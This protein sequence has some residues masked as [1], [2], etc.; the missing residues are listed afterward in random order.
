MI[1]PRHRKFDAPVR[2][3]AT[4]ALLLGSLPLAPAAIT[5][6]EWAHVQSLEV[7][8]AGLTKISLP[9]STLDLA[10]AGLADLRV[11]GPGGDEVPYLIQ[12][13]TRPAP[14]VRS[15]RATRIELQ[16]FSTQLTIETGTTHPIDRVALNTP[17]S[18]FVKAAR[19]EISTD[20]RQWELVS[21]GMQLARQPGI[22]ALTLPLNQVSASHLRITIDDARTAVVPF[23]GA[24]LHLPAVESFRTV[25]VPAEI[26]QRDEF[27]HE[28]VL[29][30][31]LPAR[32]LPLASLEVVT[33][34]PV[35]ARPLRLT[36]R[37]LFDG[38]SVEQTL[39]SGS[40]YRSRFPPRPVREHTTLPLESTTDVS[41]IQLRV[42]NADSAPLSIEG[43]RV[44]RRPV[45]LTFN[46]LAE[47][48]YRLLIGNPRATPARY[49]VMRFA[50]EWNE[51]P[52]GMFTLA[53]PR[54]NPDYQPIDLLA[55]TTLPGPAID[56]S[57]W[58]FRKVVLP[59]KA[60]VQE[61]EMD[62]ETL[63]HAKRDLADL[64]L[65][66]DNRQ[67]PYLSERSTLVRGLSL[68][69][70]ASKAANQ[71][72]ISRWT[73][74]LPLA[75]LPIQSLN[76][77]SSTRWFSRTFQVFEMIP[78][79]RGELSRHHLAE[80]TAWKST[81]D[82]PTPQIRVPLL[83]T[84]VTNTVYLETDNGDNPAISITDVSAEYP[85][86][87]LLFRADLQPMH[88]Y[89]GA[90]S[91]RAPRYDLQ[92]AAAQLLSDKR[93]PVNSGPE[94][95]T[96]GSSASRTRFMERSGG[97]LLWSTLA[98]VVAVLLFAITRLLPASS[99]VPPGK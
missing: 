12:I 8:E 46:A 47:G 71:P 85:V 84:P 13:P 5:S 38:E 64:R 37:T 25:P 28:T 68:K 81:P 22:E 10:Q 62:L 76:L 92:L 39:G 9:E 42:T 19:L 82:Q 6:S 3:L 36:Q 48:P 41:E 73:L 65:V 7:S 77:T 53:P 24:V 45:W 43:V 94:E 26:S 96:D 21:D 31:H 50:A 63:A 49:D 83:D 44:W 90:R 93:I 51:V 74:M 91:A 70:T 17:A 60:G 14:T 69:P 11:L 15:P 72:Q 34:D 87:R 88:L 79:Q 58:K 54:P 27:A 99:D 30:L 35:F 55:D 98:A 33:P 16:T 20:G 97:L 61:L 18:D 40:I 66:R 78:D 89:Y 56:V 52:E 57:E 86:I 2:R 4:F 67:I 59:A 29:M 75:G 95:R 1:V 23:S 80:F 32:H